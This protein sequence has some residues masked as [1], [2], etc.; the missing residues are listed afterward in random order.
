RGKAAWRSRG[1]AVFQ[2]GKNVGQLGGVGRGVVLSGHALA[3]GQPPAAQP[4]P[5][6]QAVREL[7]RQIRRV[8]RMKK[9]SVHPVADLLGDAAGG[10]AGGGGGVGGCRD[11]VGG[12]FVG[13]RGGH[14]GGE[15]PADE[16]GEVRT[17]SEVPEPDAIPERGGHERFQAK[18]L[19]VVV[20]AND[21]EVGI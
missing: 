14:R 3:S 4:V 5:V 10:G 16:L 9:H 17:A 12:G 15:P 2:L 20:P 6:R 21:H 18:A 11:R 1:G 13:P 7:G 8:G 19:A